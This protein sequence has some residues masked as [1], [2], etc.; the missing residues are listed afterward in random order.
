MQ[1]TRGLE[2]PEGDRVQLLVVAPATEYINYT[3]IRTLPFIHISVNIIASFSFFQFFPMT[4][5]R[6]CHLTSAVSIRDGQ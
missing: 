3:Y 4:D 6:R 2:A 5:P 1:E